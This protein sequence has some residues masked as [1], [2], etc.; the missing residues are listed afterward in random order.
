MISSGVALMIAGCAGPRPVHEPASAP[1]TGPAP[2]PELGAP[3]AASDPVQPPPPPAAAPPPGCGN[4]VQ[5]GAE[6]CDFGTPFNDGRP[7]G[8]APTCTLTWAAVP[9]GTYLVG[10]DD[11]RADIDEPPAHPVRTAGFSISST[12]VTRAQKRR[13]GPPE[14]ADDLPWGA[15]W[16]EA[17]AWCEGLGPGATLATESQWEVAARGGHDTPWPCVDEHFCLDNV[18]WYRPNCSDVGG[19]AHAVGEKAPNDLGAY[20]MLGN[21]L[22]WV[23]DCYAQ[24]PVAFGSF[25]EDTQVASEPD[26]TYRVVRGGSCWEDRWHLRLSNRGRGV[27]DIS[28]AGFRCVRSSPSAPKAAPR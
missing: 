25:V 7:G 15:S 5:D 14:S 1:A 20:D 22:E 2:R 28:R 18:A 11:R 4:A 10:S 26:C 3:L 8:C 27:Q 6:E 13:F 9:A 17:K 12:E 21:V 24:D 16:F 23:L 19:R